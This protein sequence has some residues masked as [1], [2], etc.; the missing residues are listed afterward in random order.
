MSRIFLSAWDKILTSMQGAIKCLST[1]VVFPERLNIHSRQHFEIFVKLFPYWS[2]LYDFVF[3]IHT[4]NWITIRLWEKQNRQRRQLS[5]FLILKHYSITT[6]LVR[7]HSIQPEVE[8]LLTL[9]RIFSTLLISHN[10]IAVRM[11]LKRMSI[12]N[13]TAK[14]EY[15][16]T[17]I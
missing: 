2:I 17:R 9:I 1:S 7:N 12:V 8:Q 13:L 5:H 3:I 16:I 11:T 10:S 4:A 15:I 6:T 14:K